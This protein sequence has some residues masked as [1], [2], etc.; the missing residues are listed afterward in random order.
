MFEITAAKYLK[1]YKFQ[2]CVK[3]YSIPGLAIMQLYLIVYSEN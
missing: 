3:F 1:L 2:K